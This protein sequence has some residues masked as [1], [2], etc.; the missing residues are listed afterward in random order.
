MPTSSGSARSSPTGRQPYD[1]GERL[2][3][4]FKAEWQSGHRRRQSGHP[5][6]PSEHEGRCQSKEW[7]GRARYDEAPV[8][9][10]VAVRDDKDAPP[11]TDT[12]AK[13]SNQPAGSTRRQ[14][15]PPMPTR[16]RSATLLLLLRSGWL[17]F[18]YVPSSFCRHSF[19][20][21]CPS[22][23]PFHRTPRPDST[24]DHVAVIFSFL[25]PILL[26]VLHCYMCFITFLVLSKL[27]HF[28]HHVV[29]FKF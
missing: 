6:R 8:Q 3:T 15:K 14:S 5:R 20:L 26:T 24:I 16:N 11:V 10:D 23:P 7:S 21:L 25:E 17:L 27:L 9:N 29:N 18:L 2:S 12:V 1:I 4:N 22:P 28:T 13:S 19:S